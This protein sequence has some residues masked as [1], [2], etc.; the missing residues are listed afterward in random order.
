MLQERPIEVDENSENHVHLSPEYRS[1]P[2]AVVTR[3]L[4]EHK[5]LRIQT[6]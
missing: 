6:L 1:R 5:W 3:A 2:L 4:R